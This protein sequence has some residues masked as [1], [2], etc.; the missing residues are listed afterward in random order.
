MPEQAIPHISKIYY[1]VDIYSIEMT[2]ALQ[3]QQDLLRD[4][5]IPRSV[6]DF[7]HRELD[8]FKRV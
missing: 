7:I 8:Q 1:F 3:D 2:T 4:D 5:P 6:F